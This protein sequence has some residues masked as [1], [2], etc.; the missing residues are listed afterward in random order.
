MDLFYIIFSTVLIWCVGLWI[1]FKNHFLSLGNLYIFFYAILFLIAIKLYGEDSYHNLKELNL[2]GFLHFI[3]FL[4]LFA[5]P[6]RK[7]PN[8]NLP[9]KETNTRLIKILYWFTISFCLLGFYEI[10]QNLSTGVIMLFSDSDY[11]NDAYME[12]RDNMDI[13]KQEGHTLNFISIISGQARWLSVFLF[14]YS[15]IDSRS[16]KL[17]KLLLGICL[18]SSFMSAMAKGSRFGIVVTVLQFAFFYFF[19]RTY[20]SKSYKRIIQNISIAFGIIIVLAV[21]VI[22]VSRAEAAGNEDSMFIYYD[23]YASQGIIYWGVLKIK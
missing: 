2:F 19:V 9:F 23:S 5:Y 14:L 10:Y 12:L 6:L 13:L 17:E 11:G 15:L 4:T 18:I 22:S 21:V 20:I 8:K 1:Y 16:T 3:F 7:L